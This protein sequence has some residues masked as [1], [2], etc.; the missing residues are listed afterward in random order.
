[1]SIILLLV[2]KSTGLQESC[3][4]DYH[5]TTGFN[6]HYTLCTIYKYTVASSASEEE[7]FIFFSK[8][9]KAII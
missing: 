8:L 3:L 6:V 5:K 7:E 9:A 2:S 4:S 1:M